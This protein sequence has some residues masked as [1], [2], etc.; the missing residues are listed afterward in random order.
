M[1]SSASGAGGVGCN[2]QDSTGAGGDQDPSSGPSV[3]S[4][5]SVRLAEAVYTCAERSLTFLTLT[6]PEVE[7]GEAAS[8]GPTWP[9]KQALLSLQVRCAECYKTRIHCTSVAC[10]ATEV[11]HAVAFLACLLYHS[12]GMGMW[13]SMCCGTMS[14][15][16]LLRDCIVLL[17]LINRACTCK[18]GCTYTNTLVYVIHGNGC[19]LS[20]DQC[21]AVAVAVCHSQQEMTQRKR[22]LSALC[23]RI[24][25]AVVPFLDALGVN[26]G[27]TASRDK[28]IRE[29]VHEVQ[30]CIQ[31][32]EEQQS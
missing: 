10:H 3:C 23:V 19:L 1:G 13:H 21:L 4:E 2:R 17:I 9:K 15:H 16:V 31:S 12:R 32:A 18:H 30:R 8:L 22:R 24:V 11:K 27:R 26:V 29:R 25:H 20:Q 28:H 14:W 5:Y 7:P 6:S